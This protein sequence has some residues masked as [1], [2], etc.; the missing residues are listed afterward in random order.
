MYF[1]MGFSNNIH[2]IPI[3]VKTPNGVD[4]KTY[5]IYITDLHYLTKQDWVELTLVIID[6]STDQCTGGSLEYK[7]L[8]Q[9]TPD[10]K[11]SRDVTSYRDNLFYM[12][13]VSS[14]DFDGGIFNYNEDTHAVEAQGR[15]YFRYSVLGLNLTCI[16]NINGTNGSGLT[17]S[18]S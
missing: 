6:Y 15:S 16:I 2:T 5:T 1:I 11:M 10:S 18:G 14:L 7:Q 17:K 13:G 9:S 8:I 3:R 4:N 12:A